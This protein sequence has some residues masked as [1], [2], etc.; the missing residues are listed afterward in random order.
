MLAAEP[1]DLIV[2][3]PARCLH[4]QAALGAADH[5]LHARFDKIELPKIA[6][7]VTRVEHYTGH[8]PCCGGVTLAPLPE[9]LQPGTPFNPNIVA[10]VMYLRVVHAV[11]YRRLSRL[12]R[13]LFGLAISEG[14][15]YGAFRR[16]KPQFDADVAGILARLRRARVIY[17]DETSVRVD[18]RTHWNWAEPVKVSTMRSIVGKQAEG[19]RDD[20]VV[21]HVVCP[22]RG[23]G[24]VAKVLGGHRPAIWVSALY[25]AQRGHADT[26]QVCLAHQLRDCQYAIDAGDTVFAP[27]LKASLLR[28]VVLARRQ[29]CGVVESVVIM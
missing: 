11:S 19:F 27:R 5:R 14:A 13:E 26:W 7:V 3:R 20:D 8:C 2:A 28:A 6:P 29:S 24:V 16:G 9:H 10:L 23:A 1:D 25:S 18:G 22:R 21:I 15:L 17:S 12:M 4:C